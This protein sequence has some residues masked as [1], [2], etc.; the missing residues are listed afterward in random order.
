MTTLE[1]RR[2]V[3]E[4]VYRSCLALDA[5]DWKAFL[6]AVRRRLPLHH[7]DL[8]PRDPQGHGLARPRQGRHGARCSTTC[9][10]TTATIRRSRATRPSTPSRSRTAAAGRGGVGAPGVQN[11]ARRRRDRALRGR[12]VPRHRQA[13][14]RQP[15][16]G[17]R[18]V[19]PRHAAAR[20]RLPHP[21]LSP[22]E[23]SSTRATAPTSSRPSRGEKILFAGL[24]ARVDLPYECG[25]GT[26]GTCKA[27]LVDGR[28]DDGWPEAPGRK[29]LKGAGEFLMCQCAAPSDVT[30]EVA[31][32]VYAIGL[33][34]L[35]GGARGGRRRRRA[36]ADARRDGVRD[37]ARHAR[38]S[39][40]PASSWR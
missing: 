15:H 4:L 16:A 33:G 34:R 23:C 2:A 5:K 27:R 8:Q 11:R 24:R 29:Y 19:K 22:C 13:E 12:P 17:K 35:P 38:S 20:L 18:T 3:E 39:S 1:Q 10:G 32:F 40:T 7:R 31:S 26:C 28:L 25:T 37:R 6:D 21:V 30:A 36:R 14:R 9:R